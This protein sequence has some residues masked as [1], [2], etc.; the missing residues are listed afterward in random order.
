MQEADYGKSNRWLTTL[1]VSKKAAK[2]SRNQII[3]ALEKEN[4]E[5]RPVWK[6]M[7]MQPF[8]EKCEY[9][10]GDA[11][12]V[13]ANLFEKGLCLPSGSNLSEGDQGRVIDIILSLMK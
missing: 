5:S 11:W 10:K 1:T 6:P 3:N 7:H 12:D 2:I 13:S 4:V 8:Y 9:V